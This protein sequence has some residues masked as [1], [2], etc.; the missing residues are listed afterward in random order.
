[1]KSICLFSLFIVLTLHSNGQV[2]L[3]RLISDG[4]VLQR[5]TKIN[6]WGWASVN[7]K[8]MV[9]FAD[10]TYS[11]VAG[12]KGE[13]NISLPPLKAGGPFSM[14]IKASNEIT[15]NDIFIGEVWV[16]SGQ[17]QMDINMDRVSPLY[18]EEISKAENP[19]IRNFVVPVTYNFAEPQG[20][21]PSG[22]WVPV[23]KQNILQTS[24]IAYFFA[25]ELYN[26]Y[27]VPIGMIRASVG[28]SPIEAWISEKEIKEFPAHYNEVLRLK[29]L[30]YI[31]SIQGSD[32]TRIADWYSLL[33]EK[34]EGY[35]I[36]AQP[37]YKTDLDV[38]D[39]KE[40]E[41][42]ANEQD[43]AL[44]SNGVFWFRKEVHIPDSLS[45][46]PAKLNLGRLIDADSVFVNETFVGTTSYQYPPR[47]YKIPGGLL[48]A[49]VNTIVIKLI[50]NIGQCGFVP[51]KP[52]ELIV[53][54]SRFD[55]KGTWKYKNGALMEPLRGET[56]IR[57]KPTGLYN[58]MISPLTNYAVKGIL[59]YQGESNAERPE[60]YASLFPVLIETWRKGWHCD[61]LPFLFVQLHNYMQTKKQPG[62][63]N[64]ALTREAQAKALSIPHTGM[65]VAIDLG[66]WND[67]HPLNKKDVAKRLAL[68]AYKVAYK[69][70]T[71]VYSGPLY[72]SMEIKGNKIILTFSQTGSSL[73]AKGSKELQHFAIA[74][75]D[76]K[77]VWGKAVIKDNRVIVWND[78]IP[79]PVAVRYAWA[80]NPEGANLCN[81]EGLPA[82]PFRTDNFTKESF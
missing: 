35:K 31:D 56:A 36:P 33:S 3:P 58:A 23:T 41:I 9:H 30:S 55:L 66:E 48:K 21:I 18:Q 72:R 60:E 70:G 19:Y 82:A 16:C 7:E 44:T 64:W 34:D 4:M 76:R 59:W 49:G 22:R 11:T 2:R 69:E 47:R 53:G 71:V 39:W 50:S 28:G 51:D 78:S 24:A 27:K 13:W 6:I 62:E 75:S 43:K 1:M 52:Y 8:V 5:D 81:K 61:E 12:G 63:S 26:R 73:V 25:C 42:P 57:Y 14:Q 29:N 20:D 46:R 68:A 77:F 65:A 10:S 37:W 80:D 54:E 17:S 74:G 79:H 32:K 45:G 67:I 40:I 15:L 38:S